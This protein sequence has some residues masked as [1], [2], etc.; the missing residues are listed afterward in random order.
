MNDDFKALLDEA[1]HQDDGLQQCERIG[2][3]RSGFGL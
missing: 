1:Q 2:K 3:Y